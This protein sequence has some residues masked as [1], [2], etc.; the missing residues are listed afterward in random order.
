MFERNV[1]QKRRVAIN[2]K[3]MILS[4]YECMSSSDQQATWPC[5]NKSL[6]RIIGA[7]R[8]KG[9]TYLGYLGHCYLCFKTL[10]IFLSIKYDM[11]T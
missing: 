11:G 8:N 9:V 10:R 7:Q 3:P 1:I 2:K 4:K 6:T 5:Q